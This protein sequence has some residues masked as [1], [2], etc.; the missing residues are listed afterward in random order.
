MPEPTSVQLNVTVTAV[1]FQPAPLAAGVCAPVIVGAIVSMRT[2]IDVLAGLPARS[3]TVRATVVIPSA[4][5]FT[6]AGQS[7]GA[8]PDVA[9][10]HVKCTTTDPLFQPAAFA[11]GCNEATMTGGVWST[12]MPCTVVLAELPAVSVA[13]PDAV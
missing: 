9:S 7:P 12:L 13:V 10:L 5:T 6:S 11:A 4:L 1:L 3:V 8:M 2:T